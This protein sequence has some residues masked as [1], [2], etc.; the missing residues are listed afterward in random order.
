MIVFTAR[1]N[2]SFC[3][4][5]LFGN[6]TVFS[7]TK[8]S[9]SK[10]DRPSSETKTVRFLNYQGLIQKRKRYSSET[11][12]AGPKHIIRPAPPWP[13]S[14]HPRQPPPPQPHKS[15][16]FVA[17][18]ARSLTSLPSFIALRCSSHTVAPKALVVWQLWP[19]ASSVPPPL[20]PK[21]ALHHPIHISRPLS[22]SL[23]LSL[24]CEGTCDKRWCPHQSRSV[25]MRASYYN[26]CGRTAN[27]KVFFESWR[28]HQRCQAATCRSATP[29]LRKEILR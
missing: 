15:T 18:V 23:S 17:D 9:D 16:R 2:L 26:V 22:L 4:N 19:G 24:F 1:N 10:T 27:S 6:Q 25:Y 29:E 12:K 11:T 20:A 28:Y 7:Q 8:Q 14:Q 21:E 3:G 5:G 13:E